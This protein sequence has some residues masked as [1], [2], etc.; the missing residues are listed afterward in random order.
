MQMG[1]KRARVCDMLDDN[2]LDLR[3]WAVEVF[4][5][6]EDDGLPEFK[7]ADIVRPVVES[8]ICGGCN[9]GGVPIVTFGLALVF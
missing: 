6:C 3:L 8:F 9:V 1:L 7:F 5:A 4:I 2:P